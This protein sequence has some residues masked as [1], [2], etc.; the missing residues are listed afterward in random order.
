MKLTI[1]KPKVKSLTNAERERLALLLEELGEAQQMIGKI[2][3]FGYEN[4]NPFDPDAAS[5]RKLLERELG[6]VDHAIRLMTKKGDVSLRA[7]LDAR[8][9]KRK[10][11]P[12]LFFQGV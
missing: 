3:R 6:D 1:V 8:L 10:K 11:G 9:K 7:I 5:N 2:L 4:F 12:Y